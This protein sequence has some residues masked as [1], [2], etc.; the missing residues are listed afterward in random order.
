MSSRFVG[1]IVALQVLV[2][3][4]KSAPGR[5]EAPGDTE[6]TLALTVI[7]KSTM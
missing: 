3:T 5:D 2:P 6:S 4:Q 7:A 1:A